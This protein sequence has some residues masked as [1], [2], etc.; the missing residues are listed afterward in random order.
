MWIRP[1][2]LLLVKTTQIRAATCR[3]HSFG[4]DPLSCTSIAGDVLIELDLHTPFVVSKNKGEGR[5]KKKL[6]KWT[7]HRPV[8]ESRSDPER[9]GRRGPFPKPY[10][11]ICAIHPRT[12][13]LESSLATDRPAIVHTSSDTSRNSVAG[14]S[15]LCGWRWSFGWTFWGQSRG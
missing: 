6:P 2:L 7:A 9:R 11:R 4:F 12:S 10:W 13:L 5:K 3:M 15:D 8:I 14:P 1:V